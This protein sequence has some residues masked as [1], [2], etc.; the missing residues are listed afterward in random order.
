MKFR[1]DP[2]QEYMYVLLMWWSA[3]RL[4]MTPW[5]SSSESPAENSVWPDELLLGNRELWR[6]QTR[7]VTWACFVFKS[8]CSRYLQMQR[9]CLSYAVTPCSLRT[10]ISAFTTLRWVPVSIPFQSMW[11]LWWEVALQPSAP[12]PPQVIRFLP[13]SIIPSVLHFHI[14]FIFRLHYITLSLDIVIK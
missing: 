2:W 4:Q 11:G 10:V 12:P 6:I 14:P 13:S 8:S 7:T 3:G 9:I 1:S 5:D